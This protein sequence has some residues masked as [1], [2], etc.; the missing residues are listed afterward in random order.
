M[1]SIGNGGQVCFWGT[2]LSVPPH[3]PFFL[4]PQGRKLHREGT[5]FAILHMLAYYLLFKDNKFVTDLN[6]YRLICHLIIGLFMEIIFFLQI[7]LNKSLLS[8]HFL[9]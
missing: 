4:I 3:P 5:V 1:N 2:F 6:S 7:N 8:K 9:T